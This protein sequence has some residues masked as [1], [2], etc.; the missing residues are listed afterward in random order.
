MIRTLV[1][2]LY[3]A[4][5]APSAWAG[6]AASVMMNNAFE[7]QSIQRS[8]P[9]HYAIITQILSEIG[10]IPDASV[11]HWLQ[12]DFGATDVQYTPAEPTN[13]PARRH[14]VFS[15]DGVRYE[16]IITLNSFESKT[17]QASHF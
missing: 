14:L 13:G 6:Q 8:N 11:S 12:K 17:I 4:A 5:I 15:L 16:G 1:T 7:L 9:R 2:A 10:A 3:I